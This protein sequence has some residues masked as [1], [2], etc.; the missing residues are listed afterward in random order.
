MKKFIATFALAASFAFAGA[1][2]FNVTLF[3]PSIIAGTELKPGEYKVQVDGS[4]MT[5]KQGK[6]VIEASVKSEQADTKYASTSVRYNNGDGKLTVTE[7]R[8]GGTNT[9]LVVN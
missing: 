4:K 3:Q 2:S 9:K 5:I 1:N 6:K 7:I 8:V